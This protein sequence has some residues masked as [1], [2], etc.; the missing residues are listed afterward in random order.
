MLLISRSLLALALVLLLAVT[1]VTMAVA[2]GQVHGLGEVALCT[3]VGL[4]TVA[5][6]AQGNPVARPRYCPKC[7]AGL[8]VVYFYKTPLPEPRNQTI[9]S[10]VLVEESVVGLAVVVTALARGSPILA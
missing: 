8:Y 5:V 2:R 10:F 7:T 3:G 4:V 1:S 6:D 9:I